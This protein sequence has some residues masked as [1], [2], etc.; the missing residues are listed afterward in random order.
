VITAERYTLQVPS[1]N[2]PGGEARELIQRQSVCNDAGKA[3]WIPCV[4]TK[5]MK[6]LTPDE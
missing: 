5:E 4:S 6:L 3:G 2:A 1:V